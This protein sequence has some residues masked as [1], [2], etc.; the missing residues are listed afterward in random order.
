MMSAYR[1]DASARTG[2][3]STGSTS[4]FSTVST[5]STATASSESTRPSQEPFCRQK[6]REQRERPP[7]MPQVTPPREQRG[8]RGGIEPRE[9]GL[10]VAGR[11]HGAA[12][13]ARDALQYVF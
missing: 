2:T 12:G 4:T 7:R 10:R 11:N 5:F 9:Q 13:G 8:R 3:I 6:C 1:S